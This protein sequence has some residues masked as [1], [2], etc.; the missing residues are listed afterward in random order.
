MTKINFKLNNMKEC[1]EELL[2]VGE[3]LDQNQQRLTTF[4]RSLDHS[5]R[6][7]KTIR[8]YVYTIQIGRSGN[9]FTQLGGSVKA[10]CELY[11]YNEEYK[12]FGQINN[13]KSV[14]NANNV[15]DNDCLTDY[16]RLL[17]V[18]G[19]VISNI[20]GGGVINDIIDKIII[21]NSKDKVIKPIERQELEPDD[22]QIKPI[23][24]EQEK[25]INKYL[26]ENPD[27]QSY[28]TILRKLGMADEELRNKVQ[29]NANMS[30]ELKNAL[31][32]RNDGFIEANG[33]TF[34][35]NQ[36]VA[37][38]HAKFKYYMS[39]DG[40]K[41]I[42]GYSGN[43]CDYVNNL[44]DNSSQTGVPITQTKYTGSDCLQQIVNS[45]PGE[46]VTDII[47]SFQFSGSGGSAG[48]VIYIDAI[49]DGQVYLTD[50]WKSSEI[51]CYSM[52]EFIK[53]YNAQG[54]GNHCG[55][56]IGAVHFTKN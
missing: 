28:I 25:I 29:N 53:F 32:V 13:L 33:G 17:T 15:S 20:I 48:H 52:D 6:S 42:N 36:C 50:N 51:L 7:I 47:V 12:I 22:M 40:P 18:G 54:N 10:C 49:V 26:N 19:G 41:F 55:L 46:P 31:Q 45:H 34:G 14:M 21:G 23:E 56:P 35:K 44:V 11:E 43:G 4:V 8:D 9:H 16:I 39:G 37:L 5:Q 38:T 2:T 1:A 30:L 3:I 27:K 24:S